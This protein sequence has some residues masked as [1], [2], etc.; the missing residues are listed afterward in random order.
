MAVEGL[1]TA[2]TQNKG[3]NNFNNNNNFKGN[4]NKQFFF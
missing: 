3:N 1:P 4:N 2:P